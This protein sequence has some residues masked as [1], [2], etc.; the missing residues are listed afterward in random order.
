LLVFLRVEVGRALRLHEI[1]GE[2]VRFAH[3]RSRPSSLRRLRSSSP[4]GSRRVLAPS[5]PLSASVCLSGD[6]RDRPV[7]PRS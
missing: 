6:Q 2:A 4:A 5:R 1:R 7:G 3:R